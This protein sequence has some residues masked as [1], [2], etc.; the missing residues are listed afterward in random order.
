M[1]QG[2]LNMELRNSWLKIC[3]TAHVHVQGGH[4]AGCLN[5][6]LVYTL[7][8]CGEV[9]WRELLV[10]YCAPC[11]CSH[12]LNYSALVAALQM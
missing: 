8:L 5:T 1:P 3:T 10:I 6:T 9:V 12:S 2:V 11:T 4:T 7:H